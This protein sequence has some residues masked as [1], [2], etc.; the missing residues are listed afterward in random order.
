MVME[1]EHK[2]SNS[3]LAWAVSQRILGEVIP[4]LRAIACE[5][6]GECII[7]YFYSE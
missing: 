7:L 5:W 3:N 2:R 4:S 1:K 6:I